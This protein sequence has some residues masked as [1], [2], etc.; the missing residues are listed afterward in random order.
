MIKI[1]H[2][3]WTFSYHIFI[4]SWKMVNFSSFLI[5]FFTIL[6]TILNVQHTVNIRTLIW[7]LFLSI[8]LFIN[9]KKSNLRLPLKLCMHCQCLLTLKKSCWQYKSDLF[10]L[11][12]FCG[13]IGLRSMSEPISPSLM[14]NWDKKNNSSLVKPVGTDLKVLWT[15]RGWHG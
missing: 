2:Q 11:T 9:L 3:N 14:L 7:S 8:E 12:L 13:S 15:E 6:K 1:F 4:N 10:Y 5:N